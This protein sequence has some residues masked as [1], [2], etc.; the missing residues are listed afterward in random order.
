[1]N[2]SSHRQAGTVM[3]EH[4]PTGSPVIDM[5]TDQVLTEVDKACS[6]GVRLRPYQGMALLIG[7]AT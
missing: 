3:S 7:M 4:L 2:F 1:M 5:F 6:F